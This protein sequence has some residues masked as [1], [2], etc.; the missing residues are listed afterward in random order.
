[1]AHSDN[2]GLVLP[3]KLAPIQ[4]VMIPIYKGEEE[5]RRI[6]ERLDGIASEL[7]A[8]GISVKIDDRDNVRTGFKFAEYELKGVP[9]RLAMGPRDFT[10]GTIEL[11]RRDTLHKD[12]VSLEGLTDRIVSLLDEIQQ[13]IYD[14]ALKFR[15]GMITRV[16]S[17][18]EFK[19]VLDEKGGFILA[20]WDGTPE[21]EAKIKEE[22]KAT[23]RCIPVDAPEE[24]GVD[25]ISG[26]P[27]SRRVIFAR[28]Y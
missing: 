21:T 26:K 25:M 7:K 23:I 20:H 27:S 17:Y 12:T 16:D 13:N 11:V 19:R 15:E 8:R 3:P 5:L 18:D 4:V 28:A 14:K 24:S 22:T 10:N 6:T 2:N 1:M 9:V